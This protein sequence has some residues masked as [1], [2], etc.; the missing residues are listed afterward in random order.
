MKTNDSAPRQV[1]HFFD[2][3]KTMFFGVA[4]ALR[5]TRQP[6]A[7]RQG[8]QSTASRARE[9]R[10]GSQA[11][12]SGAREIKREHSCP[13]KKCAVR[14][15]TAQLHPQQQPAS[16]CG[17][18]DCA[19]A[20]PQKKAASEFIS[21]AAS[22]TSVFVGRSF[23]SDI[24]HGYGAPTLLPAGSRVGRMAA[25]S[26]TV[27]R[28]RVLLLR[29]GVVVGGLRPVDD[30]PPCFDVVGAAIL[31]LQ[32]VGVL[33]HIEAEHGLAAVHDGIVLVRG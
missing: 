12:V 29:G 32:I 25:A 18:I 11:T 3:R 31:I 23:S 26:P 6:A 27:T 22:L 19:A 24:T 10:Q 14:T 28:P 16:V 9:I 5:P 21:A 17:R 15:T 4:P 8:S 13:Q 2:A 20:S 7:A 30:A 33:P 1:T